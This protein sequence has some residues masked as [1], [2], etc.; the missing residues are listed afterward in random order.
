M[1]Q[2]GLL[3][4][5]HEKP[6]I[7]IIAYIYAPYLQ[8]H[9]ILDAFDFFFLLYDG[10]KYRQS[11]VSY[12]DTLLPSR[13]ENMGSHLPYLCH[14]VSI[15]K[16]E[17]LGMRVLIYTCAGGTISIQIAAV[18]LDRRAATSEL[19]A[20]NKGALLHEVSAWKLHNPF[21]TQFDKITGFLR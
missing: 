16:P 5:W 21:N 12:Y 19:M 4:C 1:Q 3:I 2:I 17:E 13:R 15:L 6:D 9:R 18:A 20:V 10:L 7:S 14:R 8:I 11:N